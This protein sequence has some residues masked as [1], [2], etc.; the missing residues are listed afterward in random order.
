MPLSDSQLTN[1]FLFRGVDP[2]SVK[3]LTDRCAVRNFPAREV[4]LTPADENHS[5]YVILNGTA[6]VHLGSIESDPIARIQPGESI[7]EMSALDEGVTPS[8]FVIVES[9]MTALIISHDILMQLINQSHEVARNLLFLLS[10]RLR[11]GNLSVSNSKQLQ[12][13][14]E[15]HAN[16]DSLTGL[17]NR[18]WID[19]YFE[20]LIRRNKDQET[21]AKFSVLLADVDHF[22]VFNDEHGHLAGDHALRCVADSLKDNIRPTDIVARYG[23]EEFLVILPNTSPEVAVVVADRVIEG[24]RKYPIKMGETLYPNVTISAGIAS[25]VTGDNFAT[26]I[27]AADSGLYKAKN[28]GRN[29]AGIERA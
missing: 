20:R 10:N 6:T 16:I 9:N 15:Q 1:L 19:S 21:C 4:L 7:G 5:I 12:Q 26:L 25:L 27:D 3:H 11:S 28:N 8:A 24:M 29:Q 2:E 17:Y 23:G 18:R 14:F 13:E 22:K